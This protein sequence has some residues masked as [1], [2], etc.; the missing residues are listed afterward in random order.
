MVQIKSPANLKS[1]KKISKN[2]QIACLGYAP[3]ARS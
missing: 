2:E 1:K 3:V